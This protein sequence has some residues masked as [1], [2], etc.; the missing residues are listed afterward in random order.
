MWVGE[1]E[2]DDEFSATPKHD[3]RQSDSNPNFEET[4]ESEDESNNEAVLDTLKSLVNYLNF[5]NFGL[6]K[7][8]AG[9]VVLGEQWGQ[10]EMKN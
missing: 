7:I 9:F 10:W 2:L 3:S 6:G 5:K 1:T 8:P 4:D